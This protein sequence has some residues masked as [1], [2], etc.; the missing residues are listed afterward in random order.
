MQKNKF[1]FLTLKCPRVSSARRRIDQNV[2]QGFSSL[3]IVFAIMFT[4]S[5]GVLQRFSLKGIS[6][7]Y[8]N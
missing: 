2:T 7:K 3:L 5:A 4:V 8:Y 1:V 6:H